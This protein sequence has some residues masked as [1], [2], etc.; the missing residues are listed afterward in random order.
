M[1]PKLDRG[2]RQD[3]T[4]DRFEMLDNVDFHRNDIEVICILCREE[5]G[6]ADRE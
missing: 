5:S 1:L 4:E 2:I 3:R 6:N